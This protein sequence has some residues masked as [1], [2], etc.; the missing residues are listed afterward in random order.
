M[1]AIVK[2]SFWTDER[3]ENASAEV[4]LACLWLMT[5]PA[6]DLC[7]FTRVSNK[8]FEFEASSEV[9]ALEGAS[10]GLPS[11]FKKLP[12]GAWF[13]VNFLRH[14]FGKGGKLSLGNKV[15][16]AAARHASKLPTEQANAF[17]EAYPELRELGLEHHLK[18]SKTEGASIPHT[19][20]RDGVREREREGERER[21]ALAERLCEAHPSRAKTGPALRAALGALGRHPF[22][23]ILAGTLAYAEAV[24]AWTP[25]ERGQ[26]VKNAA[27]FFAEDIWNQ[28]A[29]NFPSRT[30]ARTTN[31]HHRQLDTGGRKPSLTMLEELYPTK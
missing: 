3:I 9:S 18:E 24:A 16:I 4:K 30:G 22:E 5:N 15:V 12:N 6:R 25:A 14:Q 17:F 8:R 10:K 2:S 13:A 26:Y 29:A 23:A 31:G 28:P 7:G 19:V 20:K 1:D 27:E 11:S 21:A